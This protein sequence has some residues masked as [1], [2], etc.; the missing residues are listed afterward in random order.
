[1]LSN[2]YI[3]YN[4]VWLWQLMLLKLTRPVLMIVCPLCSLTAAPAINKP[5]TALHPLVPPSPHYPASSLYYVISFIH[6]SLYLTSSLALQT[7]GHDWQ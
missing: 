7:D 3:L 5:A 2:W 1:M 4:E 6:P